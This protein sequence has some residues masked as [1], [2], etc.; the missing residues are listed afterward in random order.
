MDGLTNEKVRAGQ[1]DILTKQLI[2]AIL[3]SEEYRSFH[4]Y[5]AKIK[6][7]PELYARVCEF[8]KH[9]FEL[10]NSEADNNMYDEIMRFQL[11]NVSLRQNELVNDFLRAELAICRMLHDITNEIVDNV[12]FD[13]EFL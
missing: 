5:L 4:Y 3:D 13:I 11:E 12:D 10:Q 1:V 7:Q 8:R 2:S 6:E 9:N